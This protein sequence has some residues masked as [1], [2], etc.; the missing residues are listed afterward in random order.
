MSEMD[1]TSAPLDK[2]NNLIASGTYSQVQYLIDMLKPGD[3]AALLESSP[4][5]QRMLI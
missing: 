4:V 3:V 5:K 1:Q 2:L